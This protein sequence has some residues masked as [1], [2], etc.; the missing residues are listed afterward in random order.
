MK[1]LYRTCFITD[2]IKFKHLTIESFCKK[3]N[4]EVADYEK[5]MNNS[6]EVEVETLLRICKV[7]KLH[8]SNLFHVTERE[9]KYKVK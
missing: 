1:K 5:V 3:C 8:I 2:Y 9:L 6:T 4:I 7:I